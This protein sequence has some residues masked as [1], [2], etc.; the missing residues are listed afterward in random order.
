MTS[1]KIVQ[2]S[3]SPSPLVPL[4]SLA[5]ILP[6]PFP[7]TSNLKRNPL[8]PSPKYQLKENSLQRWLLYV[9]RPFLQVGFCFQY[10]LINLVWVSIDFFCFSWSKSC[11]QSNFK[12]LKNSF[13]PSSYSEKMGWGR[14][15]AEASL[16]CVSVVQKYHDMFF[17]KKFFLVLILQSTCFIFITS[18]R[19]QIM[20]QQ[21][22]CTCDWTK[23]NNNNNNKKLRHIQI[24]HALYCSI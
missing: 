6:T 12:K 5:Y 17:L 11:P 23:S 2:F 7:W 8:P 9:I 13:L 10:Q 3:R 18:K 19:K 16:S 1:M 15:W 4:V 20:E 22:H 14:S 24:D 21:P